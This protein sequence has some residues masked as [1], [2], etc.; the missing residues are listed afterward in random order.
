MKFLPKTLVGR[1]VLVLLVGLSV[2]HLISIGIYSGD[3]QTALAT[4]GGKQVA[5]RIAAATQFVEGLEPAA[6]AGA[7][8]SFW[9]PGF[10]VTWT[11]ESMIAKD[12]DDWRARLVR[13]ALGFYL[14]DV[15]PQRMRVRYA[16]PPAA[17]PEA[18][19]ATNAERS[20]GRS[21]HPWM[22]MERHM[23]GMTGAPSSLTARHRNRMRDIWRGGEILEVS[24]QLTDTSWLNFA[25]PAE[26]WQS[27]WSSPVFLS[28]ILMTVAVL[29]LSVW[30]IRTATRPLGV[31]AA[32]ADRLGLD[33]EA[34]AL[35]ETGPREVQHVARA[36][37]TMQN[38]IRTFVRDRTQMLAAISHDLRTPITRLRLRAEFI[39]DAD[40]QKKMLDDLGQME[41]MIASTLAF[42]RDDA[43][44]EPRKPFDLAVLLRGL[45]DDAT[46][47]G[48]AAAYDGPGRLAY[49]GR[50]IALTRVFSNLIDN[51]VSYGGNVRVNLVA[52][53]G[54]VT[55]TV[56]DDGP[57]IP[58]DQLEQV[59]APFHRVDQ[60]RSR[61][62]GG[63]GLGLSVV[64]SI[65]RAHGGEVTLANRAEGGLLATVILPQD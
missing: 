27:F 26:R 50:P 60:S 16:M 64:R 34:T 5:E 2:S 31:I 23:R 49:S 46:D 37:N 33:I 14:D 55:V 53:A 54:Q 38:R 8:K 7:L 21:G 58:D 3:R 48:Q 22:E 45:C 43:A 39:D 25:S 17:S 47:A 11:P 52:D 61:E 40:L 20:Q 30:A 59:F 32:A 18:E 6:R 24:V 57:G 36:F 44:D 15:S 29:G 10:S 13:S 63:V 28:I 62:T 4:V 51:G 35:D 19:A 1:T 41:A 65:V 12:N 9:G 42:A 56:T